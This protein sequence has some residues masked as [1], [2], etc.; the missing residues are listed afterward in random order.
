[1]SYRKRYSF[2]RRI[3]TVCSIMILLSVL[4]LCA[5]IPAPPETPQEEMIRHHWRAETGEGELSFEENTFTMILKQEKSSFTLKG[6]YLLSEEQLTILSDNCGVMT[7]SF[8]IADNKLYLNYSG[9]ECIFVKADNF[10]EG[11]SVTD[12]EAG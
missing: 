12:S 1:M 11:E 7:M 8:R 6:E 3:R 2:A 10:T 4:L 9:K 5:C